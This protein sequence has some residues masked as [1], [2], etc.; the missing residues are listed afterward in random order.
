MATGHG[1]RVGPPSPCSQTGSQAPR[2]HSPFYRDGKA[3]VIQLA[4]LALS[5]T[6]AH[7]DTKN[8]RL[9]R[10]ARRALSCSQGFKVTNKP[11]GGPTCTSWEPPTG[12]GKLVVRRSLQI[13]KQAKLWSNWRYVTFVTHLGGT[14]VEVD[15]IQRKRA[16]IEL[17]ICAIE[18][19]A[20]YASSRATA[21]PMAPGSHGRCSPT[22][23]R[24]G[25]LVWERSPR[26]E[27]LSSQR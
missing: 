11:R 7:R 13:A 25:V 9:P 20:P 12:T 22:T 2:D 27:L 6:A 21:L 23:C 24:A 14:T 15:R 5:A 10:R 16:L 17:V 4:A 26:L 19:A 1:S 8:L 18:D 3:H